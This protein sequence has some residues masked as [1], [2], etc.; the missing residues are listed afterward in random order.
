MNVKVMTYNIL[1]GGVQRE[2]LLLQV[3]KSAN[4]DVLILQEVAEHKTI[5]DFSSELGMNLFI[6]EGGFSQ[7]G[8]ALL[9]RFPIVN[10][11][12]IHPFPPI[13]RTLLSAAVEVSPKSQLQ[14][15]GVHLIPHPQFLLE[16]W[17]AWEVQTILKQVV[18]NNK[19]F[20]LIAGGL[21]AVAPGDNFSTHTMPRLLKLM[22]WTQGGLVFRWAINRLIVFGFTD[23]Y[24]LL[25][26]D[27]DGFTLPPPSPTIRLDYIFVNAG[28]KER[29][30]NCNVITSPSV[31]NQASDHYP[32]MAEFLL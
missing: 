19:D 11:K 32:I 7:H 15:Y 20:Y 28:L 24:R 26:P 16:L 23:C 12:S 21:N 10:P 14:I 13:S 29:L 22:L 2:S 30:V 5:H 6:A 8:I 27:E 1:Y 18:A 4:P 25:H 17:R 9:S 31:V 3:I